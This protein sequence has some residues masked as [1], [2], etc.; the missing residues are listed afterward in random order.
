MRGSHYYIPEGC[1]CQGDGLFGMECTAPEHAELRYVRAEK[2]VASLTRQLARFQNPWTVQV[3]SKISGSWSQMCH[4]SP[5]T[6]ADAEKRMADHQKESPG[7]VFRVIPWSSSSQ[8]AYVRESNHFLTRQLEEA[9]RVCGEMSE[10]LDAV[11]IA[12][13]FY[14]NA[15]NWIGETLTG[16]PDSMPRSDGGGIAQDAL[17]RLAKGAANVCDADIARLPEAL[18]EDSRMLDYILTKMFV[19]TNVGPKTTR[20]YDSREAIRSAMEEGK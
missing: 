10:A 8:S 7:A 5:L 15:G 2:Q 3:Q 4:D 14:A 6:L 18:D 17:D 16:L 13:E 1:I 12:L 20:I 11:R 9:R 19:V